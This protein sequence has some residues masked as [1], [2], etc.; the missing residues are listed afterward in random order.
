VNPE[1]LELLR[2]AEDSVTR[3]LERCSKTGPLYPRSPR[4]V[5]Q[6][7]RTGKWLLNAV[8]A[9]RADLGRAATPQSED[10]AE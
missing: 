8:T 4:A 5:A 6:V 10:K 3:L 2:A 9:L 7:S 1:T